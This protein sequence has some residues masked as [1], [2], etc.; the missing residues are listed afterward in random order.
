RESPM[1]MPK[2]TAAHRLLEKLAGTWQGEEKMYPSPWSPEGGMA[3][4]RIA[5]RV[6]LDGFAVIG[7]YQQSRH[8]TVTFC[9]HSVFTYHAF[10]KCYVLYWFDSMGM[11]ANLFRGQFDGDKLTVTSTSPQ[12]QSRLQYEW[13]APGQMRSRMEISQDGQKWN[14]LFE[15]TYRRQ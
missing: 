9:G 13:P 12:G 1:D 3:Q 2:P 5:S 14:S 6:A 7:D 8:G 4:A 11:P 15:G 10:E